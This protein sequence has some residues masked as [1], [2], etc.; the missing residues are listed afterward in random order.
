MLPVPVLTPYLS[1]LWLGLVTPFYAR[2]GRK[3]IESIIHPTVVRDAA[4]L[5]T[6]AIRPAGIE[7]AIR[8]ALAREE[9]EFA[10]TRWSDALSS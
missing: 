9:R 7:E 4:A 10:E 5:R 1:S 6:F 2:V 3:L 8:R